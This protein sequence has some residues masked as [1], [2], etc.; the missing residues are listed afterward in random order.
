[1]I[2]ANAG[3][4]PGHC[5]REFVAVREGRGH[6]GSQPRNQVFMLLSFCLFVQLVVGYC[7]FVVCCS[8]CLLDILKLPPSIY[9]PG[10]NLFVLLF[11]TFLGK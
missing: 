5:G 7:W 3:S 4:D 9:C 2:D 6:P 1:M 8:S 11:A 10:V